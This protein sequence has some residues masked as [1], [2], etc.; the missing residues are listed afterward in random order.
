MQFATLAWAH[1]ICDD[2]SDWNFAQ[3]QKGTKIIEK[4]SHKIKYR[5]RMNG[6]R[7]VMD[8]SLTSLVKHYFKLFILCSTLFSV[9]SI[10][11][12]RDPKAYTFV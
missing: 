11:K 1:V 12:V 6:V 4:I 3:I 2:R 7:I 9:I 5:F 8:I 10:I